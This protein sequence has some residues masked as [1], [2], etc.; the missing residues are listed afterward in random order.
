MCSSLLVLTVFLH[1]CR[2]CIF[3]D[4]FTSNS[5]PWQIICSKPLDWLRTA[6]FLGLWI[7]CGRIV[8]FL[9][10]LLVMISQL[11]PTNNFWAGLCSGMVP[12]NSS[13]GSPLILVAAFISS[14]CSVSPGPQLAP[15]CPKEAFPVQQGIKLLRKWRWNAL[16]PL[17]NALMKKYPGCFLLFPQKLMCWW[18][19]S[20]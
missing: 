4:C 1:C 11:L 7:V 15:Y 10:L 9:S 2:W 8:A 18:I 13:A 6:S 20:K 17:H 3:A 12:C 14:G 5:G 19:L 16:L